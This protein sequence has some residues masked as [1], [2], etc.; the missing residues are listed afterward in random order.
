[1]LW[2]VD[3]VTTLYCI[4][5]T[6][7]PH[8]SHSS[9]III[10][11]PPARGFIR[12]VSSSDTQLRVS[13]YVYPTLGISTRLWLTHPWTSDPSIQIL[14]NDSLLNIFYLYRPD[15]LFNV[16]INVRDGDPS[17]PKC[18]E[19]SGKCW[20]YKFTH[21]C[22]WWWRLIFMSA[23]YLKLCLVCAPGTPVATMLAYFPTLP[24]VLNYPCETLR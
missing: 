4:I 21:V 22:Q 24:I 18:E 10:N 2:H 19:W 5:I 14:D 15:I 12:S 3:T 6:L 23:S 16:D 7:F 9:S 1:M 8:M 17:P 13:R 11:P 20:W